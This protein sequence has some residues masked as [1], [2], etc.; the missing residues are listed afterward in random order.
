[1]LEKLKKELLG[2]L[3]KASFG[4]LDAEDTYLAITSVF[5]RV[6]VDRE[7][8]AEEI[9]PKLCNMGFDITSA[10]AERIA[11]ALSKLDFIEVGE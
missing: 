4:K 1:M 9:K 3:P 2:G 10:G 11:N 8:I 5:S 6:R 7:K